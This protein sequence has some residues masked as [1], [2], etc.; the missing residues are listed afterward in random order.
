[1]KLSNLK[2]NPWHIV[3]QEFPACGL[4]VEKWKFLLGYAILAPSS[5]NSQPWLF[6]IHDSEI[7]LQAD[8]SRACRKVD[9]QDRELIMS[10]GC[11]LFHLRVAMRH[12][13]CLGEMEILP[14]GG[15]P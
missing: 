11:A 9:P 7:E 3:E 12:F 10:C 1:M 8:F 2:P 4:P 5:H 15:K 6:H 13:G 14:G